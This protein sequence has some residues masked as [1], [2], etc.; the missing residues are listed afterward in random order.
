MADLQVTEINPSAMISSDTAHRSDPFKKKIPFIWYYTTPNFRFS[1]NQYTNFFMCRILIWDFESFSLHIWI[2]FLV[3]RFVSV[4]CQCGPRLFFI[5]G[6][7]FT[8]L[9]YWVTKAKVQNFFL[10]EIF[11]DWMKSPFKWPKSI[12]WSEKSTRKWKRPF[13]KSQTCFIRWRISKKER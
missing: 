3:C 1:G 8:D 4:L 5:R 2:L 9:A 7:P 13:E 10:D 6:L 11:C 12:R